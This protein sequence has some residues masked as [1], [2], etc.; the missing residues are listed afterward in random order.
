MALFHKMIPVAAV[1]AGLAVVDMLRPNLD[2]HAV[3]SLVIT[4][5]GALWVAVGV[6]RYVP[7]R[8]GVLLL[9]AATLNLAA[10]VV[11]LAPVPAGGDV[12]LAQPSI[13]DAGWLI[14]NPL[15]AVALLDALTRREPPRFVVLD[16]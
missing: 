14:G 7:G 3:L 9:A 15:L 1:L 8:V 5:T 4:A 11:W 2:S 16:V 10:M 6:W 12:T 13:A